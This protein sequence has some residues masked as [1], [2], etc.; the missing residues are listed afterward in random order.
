[1]RISRLIDNRMSLPFFRGWRALLSL[2]VLLLSSGPALAWNAAGHRLVAGIAWERLDRHTR[3]VIAQ[4]LR[5]HP[6]YVR[7]RDRAGADES[8]RL[9]FIEA[10]TW[11]DDIRSDNRF[12]SAGIDAPTPLLPGFPDM[13]RHRDWH[14]VNRPLDGTP[15]IH[16]QRNRESVSGMLEQQ[17]VALGKVLSALGAPR[18]TRVYAL[19]W[20]I[21]LVGDAHQPLHTS[22]R[23]DAQGHWDRLGNGVM[24][25]NPFNPRK[26][27][28]TLHAYWDDLPGPPWLRGERLDAAGRALTAAY[29]AAPADPA[30]S[31]PGLWIEESWHLARQSA[32]P[33]DDEFVP[34]L[35]A[36]F[37]DNAKE[38]AR[39]RIAEAGYRLA[40]LLN[41]L[42]G[43]P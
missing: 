41:E 39:R 19:P 28:S 30:R 29:P 15:A 27:S 13:E 4:L 25:I 26:P 10:S 42:L 40:D 6:D 8:G 5:D 34:T 11:P 31:K 16:A 17:L 20:M 24:V 14:Y 22:I 36:A 37:H 35:S 7:W 3:T 1:M 23:L 2:V 43:E 18:S 21:H 33:P 9:A 12:Y 38:I 32:Y